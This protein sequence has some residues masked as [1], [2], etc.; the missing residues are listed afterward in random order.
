MLL[1]AAFVFARFLA[2]PLRELT[3]AVGRVGRG[4]ASGVVFDD[5]RE[6]EAGSM[7]KSISAWTYN[8]TIDAPQKLKGDDK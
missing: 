7:E 6:I 1:V 2:R 4:V 3:S 8:A 5:D